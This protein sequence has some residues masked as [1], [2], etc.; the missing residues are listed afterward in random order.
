M[1]PFEPL[2]VSRGYIT[3]LI[4]LYWYLASA[5]SEW[6]SSPREL[7]GHFYDHH[8]LFKT[9]TEIHLQ[10][11]WPIWQEWRNINLHIWKMQHSR[12]LTDYIIHT[13]WGQC[14]V[15]KCKILRKKTVYQA[16]TARLVTA[17]LKKKKNQNVTCITRFTGLHS[18]W[19]VFIINPWILTYR[20]NAQCLA[21]QYT[22]YYN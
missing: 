12:I 21:F 19:Y 11:H 10:S 18:S 14:Y 2:E 8:S 9:H 6:P 15:F 13:V 20:L 17:L 16:Y 1:F 7:N 4:V 5:V 3:P 22:F